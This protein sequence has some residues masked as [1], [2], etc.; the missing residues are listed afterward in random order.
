MEDN[1]GMTKITSNL[2]TQHPVREKKK[3]MCSKIQLR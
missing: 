2:E 1:D 3:L